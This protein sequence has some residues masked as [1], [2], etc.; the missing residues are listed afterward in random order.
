MIQQLIKKGASEFISIDG[1][2]YFVKIELVSY[3]NFTDVQRDMVKQLLDK[4]LIAQASL[5][6]LGIHNVDDRLQK[7]GTCNFG[8]FDSSADINDGKSLPEYFDCGM[9]GKC[10]V[11][12]KLCKHIATENG[13]LNHREIDVTKLIVRD[14]ADK[15]I[16]DILHISENT[17]HTHRSNIQHKIGCNSK[18]G[19]GVWA[20]KKGI[21]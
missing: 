17:V 20:I 19:I 12:G 13:I 10:P 18:V 16:A 2:L 9:R 6:V 11:E 5:N 3:E 14:L 4:D 15:Q 8:G 1:K 7:F 21:V